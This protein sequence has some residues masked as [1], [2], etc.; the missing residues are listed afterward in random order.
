MDILIYALETDER[1]AAFEAPVPYTPERQ[2][3]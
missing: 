3:A 1:A 2:A